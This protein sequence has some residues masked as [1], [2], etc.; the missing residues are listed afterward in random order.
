MKP[1]L[2]YLHLIQDLEVL[3][4]VMPR[5]A[6]RPDLSVRICLTDRL[7]RDERVTGYMRASGLRYETV[8]Y[9]AAYL[10]WLPLLRPGETVVTAAESSA[11][12]HRTAHRLAAKAERTGG[13]AM[14]IQH[15]FE[16]A[17]LTY[18]DAVDPEGSVRFASGRVLIWGPLTTL[19]PAVTE[20]IRSKCVS[21][22]YP[23][24]IHQER[25]GSKGTI[26][27][28][29]NLHWHRY[30]P[31]YREMFVEHLLTTVR[32]NPAIKFIL[33]PHPNSQWISVRH[34]AELTAHPNLVLADRRERS[35]GDAS[36]TTIIGQ[37]GAVITTLSTVALD[38]AV[39]GR[40][41]A[42]A[43]YDAD[44]GRYEP[45]TRLASA[46]DWQD[47]VRRTALEDGSAAQKRS[48]A[49][50]ARRWTIEGSAIDRILEVISR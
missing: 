26:G 2:F 18:F 38:A 41:V 49:E 39:S 43:E 25:C 30:S 14:T 28:F 32:T 7:A 27:I 20:E 4:A 29:S 48:A 44:A 22:G 12:A 46:G 6:R 50:F 42:V 33:R 35:W 40:P 45:L 16:Q 31:Y 23:K 47:F 11:R 37:V 1:V 5:A 3:R 34:R 15:G 9:A 24:D 17:G 13:R 21:V 36:V 10:G 19:H 8:P